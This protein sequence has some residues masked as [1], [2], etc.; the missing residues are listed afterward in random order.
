MKKIHKYNPFY[1]LYLYV[2]MKYEQF[3]MR[4]ADRIFDFDI[5]LSDN[6]DLNEENT[7]LDVEN[8]HLKIENDNLRFENQLLNLQYKSADDSARYWSKRYWVAIG[9]CTEEEFDKAF[10]K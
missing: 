1:T 3:I 9:R 6:I 4:E 8:L 2:K 5:I 10:P 7:H